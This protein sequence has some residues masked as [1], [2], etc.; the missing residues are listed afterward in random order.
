VPC[1]HICFVL[2]LKVILLYYTLICCMLSSIKMS[3]DKTW[4][5]HITVLPVS[6]FPIFNFG[7]SL[8]FLVSVPYTVSLPLTLYFCR[9][10]SSAA[11]QFLLW[12]PYVIGHA[13][14][15]LPCDFYLSSSFFSSPNLSGRRLDVY[16]TST[17]RVALV[18]I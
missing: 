3:L 4:F 6:S 8:A 1:L 5:W 11:Y 14:I 16:H 10:D 12:P 2:L 18:R 17:H 13:I 15:F 7:V 9:D